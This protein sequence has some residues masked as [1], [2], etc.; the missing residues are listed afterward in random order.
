MFEDI[1]ETCLYIPTEISL[2]ISE[3]NIS[4]D[5]T[6]FLCIFSD[7]TV[8]V[9]NLNNY[10]KVSQFK[11]NNLKSLNKTVINSKMQQCVCVFDF[12]IE[13]WSIKESVMLFRY[14]NVNGLYIN[15]CE[16]KNLNKMSNLREEKIELLI[17][18]GA[19]FD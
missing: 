11:V 6:L 9:W 19:I 14:S 8:Q 5:H 16:M 18:E 17:Q 2:S 3:Y 15:K 1:N 13:V 7:G 4:N 10:E 12:Y